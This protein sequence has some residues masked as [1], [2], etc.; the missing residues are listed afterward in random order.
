MNRLRALGFLAGC[1]AAFFILDGIYAGFLLWKIPNE[2]AWGTRPYYNFEYRARLLETKEKSP[3]RE[4]IIIAGSSI[5]IYSLSETLLSKNIHG[6]PEV[7]TLAHEGLSVYELA[8][9]SRRIFNAQPDLIILPLGTVDFRL[10][11]RYNV[12][13]ISTESMIRDRLDD[14]GMKII[15]P[16]QSLFTFGEH[17]NFAQKLRLSFASLSRVYRYKSLLFFPVQTW[18][19]NRF[20]SGKS[21]HHYS[22]IRSG[23]GDITVRGHTPKQFSLPVT[24][25]LLANGLYFQILN[26]AGDTVTVFSTESCAVSREFSPGWQRLSLDKSCFAGAAEISVRVDQGIYVPE[27]D[28][29]YGVRLAARTGLTTP[30]KFS[31]ERYKMREDT[32]YESMPLQR[33]KESYEKRVTD[34]AR[35]ETVYFRAIEHTKKELSNEPFDR[36]FPSMQAL[37][38]FLERAR[39]EPVPVLVLFAPES[40]LSLVYYQNSQWFSGFQGYLK[41]SAV[42]SGHTFQNDCCLYAPNRFYDMHHLTFQASREYSMHVSRLVNEKIYKTGN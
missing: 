33:Y 23:R 3:G 1:A 39:R 2:S 8:A 12:Q 28:D 4:R 15:D 36:H 16:A 7:Y 26:P 32:L 41:N 5:A 29:T 21:F 42:E 37:K 11:R 17:L 34:P 38:L 19:D 10:E 24:D 27:R 20:A 31:Y 13:N 35:P 9:Y 40:E 30:R 25:A 18:L 14:S 6:N 22:G